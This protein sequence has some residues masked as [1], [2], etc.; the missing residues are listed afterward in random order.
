MK[1]RLPKRWFPIVKSDNLKLGDALD[2]YMTEL[3]MSISDVDISGNLIGQNQEQPGLVSYYDG[4]HTDLEMILS[5]F[6][7][8][9]RIS[10]AKKTREWG[11]SPPTNTKLAVNEQKLLLESEDDVIFFSEIV[12]E[13]SYVYKHYA[14]LLKALEARG[15]SLNNISK[16]RVANMEEVE[17]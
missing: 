14:S 16:L 4:M 5:Y 9:L 17:V 3:D 1:K 7:R 13:V 11:D 8:M 10:K 15:Y 6:E 2:W 12:E